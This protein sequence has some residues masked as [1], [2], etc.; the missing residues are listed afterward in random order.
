MIE[1]DKVRKAFSEL[2]ADGYRAYLAHFKRLKPSGPEEVYRRFLFS[3]LS[4]QTDWMMNVELYRAL[5]D[6]DWREGVE[7]VKAYFK[8]V[9]AGFHETRPMRLHAFHTAFWESP[10][11]FQKSPLES[12]VAYRDRLDSTVNGL[13]NAKLGFVAEMMYPDTS[14]LVCLDRHMLRGVFDVSSTRWGVRCPR[15]RYLEYERRWV[16][17]ARWRGMAPAVSRLLHWDR[18]LGFD[19]SLFWTEVFDE[20]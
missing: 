5:R 20:G 1:L 2:P 13:S 8:K 4:V 10:E 7:P 3:F 17:E 18:A 19:N 12:W 11:W 14:E 16:D 9:G 15:K 6:Y